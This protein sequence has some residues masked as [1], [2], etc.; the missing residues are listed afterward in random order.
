MGNEELR[1]TLKNMGYPAFR[2]DQINQWVF[3][4]HIYE[5]ENMTNL[6]RRSKAAGDADRVRSPGSR[7]ASGLFYRSDREVPL[8]P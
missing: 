7:A 1:E 4:K 2:A 3:Q 8:G 6:R 5:P